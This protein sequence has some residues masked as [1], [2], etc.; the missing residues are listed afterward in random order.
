MATVYLAHDIALDR[1]V[2]I[3]IMN[4]QLLSGE[5]MNERFKR[6]AKTA[7][8]LSH[9]HIIPIYVVRE[10]P[11]ILF[12][13]MKFVQGR[14]LEAIIKEKGQLPIKMVQ[15][16]LTQ[17]GGALG[18]AHRRGV[19][20]RDIKPANI[21]IDEEGWA[22]V[23]DFGIAKVTEAKNLT[24]TGATVGTPYYMSPEQATA[25]NLSGGSDQYSLGIV[26]YEMLSGKPPFVGETIM[27]I[28]RQHFFET[29]P[30][31]AQVRPDCPAPLA[32]AVARMLEKE[33][34]K[35]FPTME[36]A[37]AAIGA[38]HVTHDDP[39]HTQMVKLAKTSLSLKPLP[40]FA[41]PKS[42]IPAS[43][44]MR[45]AQ[46][47]AVSGPQDATVKMAAPPRGGPRPVPRKSRWPW[48][49]ALLVLG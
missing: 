37:V 18:Y 30:P 46:P 27:D 35:R 23:T 24:M 9:P 29:P 1:K 5:G 15:A 44:P 16:I 10:T 47:G 26:A 12:F 17:V 40:Q 41:T 4:P 20:H 49:V 39:V 33:Q 6:E 11:Q 48:V 28:M 45:A 38:T 36:E 31:L 21:M 43:R 25:K 8:Q 7:A 2:A 32:Q 22:V 14:G 3:K 13:V 34:E 19:V 42:P